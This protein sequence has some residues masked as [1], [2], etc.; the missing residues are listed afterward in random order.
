MGWYHA[1][2]YRPGITSILDRNAGTPK[3]WIT[4]SEV[5]VSFTGRL[6]GSTSL[7]IEF[8]SASVMFR[9]LPP[10]MT[11][12]PLGYWAFHIHCLPMTNTSIES[13]GACVALLYTYAPHA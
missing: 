5:N 9:G 7:P 13:S 4:S 12:W 2:E 3:S 10:M 1:C 11:R 6:T 8:R